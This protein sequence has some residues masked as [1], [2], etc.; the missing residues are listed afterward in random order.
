VGGAKAAAHQGR[1]C[2]AAIAAQ[3]NRCACQVR[4]GTRHSAN[5]YV[6]R[7]AREIVSV[8]PPVTVVV[9]SARKVE[10]L[11]GLWLVATSAPPQTHPRLRAAS[12][13]RRV[14]PQKSLRVHRPVHNELNRKLNFSEKTSGH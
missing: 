9:A 4:T 5:Q 2:A 13:S 12:T 3:R 11:V 8:R 1:R 7:A 6:L 10:L 14:P